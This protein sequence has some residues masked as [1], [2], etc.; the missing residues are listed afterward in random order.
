MASFKL[1]LVLYFL[2]LSLVPLAGAT[3]A[4][5]V[6]G[7]RSEIDRADASLN[8][9]VRAALGDLS[10]LLEG[11]GTE[12]RTLAASPD[13]QD[14]LASADAGALSAAASRVSGASFSSGGRPIA[15]AVP[16]V[17]ASRSVDVV[18]GGRAI[19]RVTVS[20]PLDE[21]FLRRVSA[22]AGLEPE[23]RLLLAVDGRIA[24]GQADLVGSEAAPSLAE[25]ADL[26]LDGVSY[27]AVATRLPADGHAVDLLAITSRSTIDTTITD[28]NLRLI[29]A[30]LGSLAIVA[31]LAWF[32]GRAVVS[33]LRDIGR[34]AAGIARGKYSERVPVR[35]RDEFAR[36]GEAFNE[37]AEQLQQR[38]SELSEERERVRRAVDRLGV[39]LAAGTEPSAILRVIA[40]SVVEATG[41]AGVAI[42]QADEQV[43]IGRASEGAGEA[44]PVPLGTGEKAFDSF[45]LYPPAGERLSEDAVSAARSLATQATI[46]LENARLHRI[47]GQQ[48]VTDDLTQ[49]ANRRRFEEA[50]AHE[51]SRVRRF[52]GPLALLIADLDD[53]KQ[54]NDRFGHQLG[55]RVLQTFA[56]ALRHAVRVVDIAARPGGEEFAVILPGTTLEEAATVAERIRA[57]FTAQPVE[58][59]DGTLVPLT[60]SFGV[61]AW[62]KELS[63]SELFAAADAALYAAKREGKNRVVAFPEVT[64]PAT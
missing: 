48:A 44:V 34:A 12:A 38:H 28:L 7:K 32:A 25:P 26:E 24:A 36:L 31:A 37:M 23:E 20:V 50:L 5:S 35:G 39:A 13:V 8:K 21:S 19:G 58:A 4:F 60:A 57:A 3:W 62:T 14:A 18:A 11:A 41:A 30:A 49:L 17:R 42:R 59:T 54:I 22:A 9:S 16:P 40:E 63:A 6:A 27:R 47:L 55:D 52:G 64:S 61:C 29:L 43:T 2:L 56:D 46:A 33:S 53:F 10:L 1:R 45:V 51:V 15:G